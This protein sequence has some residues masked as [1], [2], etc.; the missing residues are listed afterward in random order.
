MV[1]SAHRGALVTTVTGP[2]PAPVELK[3]NGIG[4][5]LLIEPQRSLLDVLRTELGLTGAKKCCDLGECG[6]CTVLVDGQ[7][8]YSCLNLAIEQAGHEILTIEGLGADGQLDPVQ[9]AFV[10]HDA[11]Q[12]GF[13]TPGQILAARALLRQN[14]QPTDE[15]IRHAMA[16]NL[17]RCGTYTHI[18]AALRSLRRVTSDE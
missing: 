2:G 12:C 4:H 11:I 7:A 10:D 1:R 17:C 13:C 15:E 3:V 16:G 8:V 18:L 9:Q 14:P 6:T 5:R